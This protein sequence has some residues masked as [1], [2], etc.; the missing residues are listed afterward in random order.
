MFNMLDDYGRSIGN[1]GYKTISFCSILYVNFKSVAAYSFGKTWDVIIA[2][3]KSLDV[4]FLHLKAKNPQIGRNII[5][6]DIVGSLIDNLHALTHSFPY[7]Y[8]QKNTYPLPSRTLLVK[9]KSKVGSFRKIAKKICPDSP[10]SPKTKR[11][12]LDSFK[13]L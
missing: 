9:K 3:L 10:I 2:N 13:F 5:V 1:M 4:W 6:S 12:Y 11:Y 7:T 8:F